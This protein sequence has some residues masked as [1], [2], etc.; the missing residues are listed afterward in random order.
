MSVCISF[1]AVIV[2]L[3]LLALLLI[4]NEKTLARDHTPAD[5]MMDALGKFVGAVVD[6]VVKHAVL[7]T[8]IG[9]ALFGYFAS[10]HLKLEPRYRLADQVPDREQALAASG[11]IDTQAHGRQS[12][13]RDDPLDERRE[14]LRSGNPQA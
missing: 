7:Y 5:G 9:F 2:V 14:P 4:R 8:L 12:V 1:V 10:L 6:R 11:R 3:P 13:P